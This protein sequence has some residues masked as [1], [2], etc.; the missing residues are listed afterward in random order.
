MKFKNWIKNQ[1]GHK[2]Q[3]VKSNNSIEYTSYKFAK[4]CHDAWIEHQYIVPYTP[5]QN[6]VSERKN[7][8]IMEMARCLLFKKDFTQ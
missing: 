2:I 7:R 6:G 4:F 5:Q 8:T 1:S 3:A